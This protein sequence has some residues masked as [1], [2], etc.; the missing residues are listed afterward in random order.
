M[1]HGISRYDEARL[2]HERLLHW[3]KQRNQEAATSLEEADMETLT[4]IQ[5]QAGAKLRKTLLSTNPIESAFDKVRMKSARV[6]RW[7][8]N[9]DQIQRWSAV[10]LVAA[11]KG[12]RALRGAREIPDFLQQIKTFNLPSQNEAA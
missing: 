2:E 10:G 1:L 12:F 4:V 8:K 6:K 7:R 3:L 11:E 5:L 9:R